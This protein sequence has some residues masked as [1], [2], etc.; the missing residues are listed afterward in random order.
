M[1]EAVESLRT[2]LWI[3]LGA[4]VVAIWHSKREDKRGGRR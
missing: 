1:I 2:L 4:I 3:I